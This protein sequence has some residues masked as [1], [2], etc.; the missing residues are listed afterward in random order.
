MA[1]FQMA[2]GAFASAA[3]NLVI[4]LSEHL[5]AADPAKHDQLQRAMV[6]GCTVA[7]AMVA[8]AEGRP[9]IELEVRFPD[10]RRDRIMSVNAQPGGGALHS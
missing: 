1:E 7:L 2:T 4:H 5:A 3:A 8:G 9:R 10:G 6:A